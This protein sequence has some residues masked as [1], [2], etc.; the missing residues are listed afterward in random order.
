MPSPI[1]S[2][3]PTSARSVSTSYSSMRCLRIEVISSGR[4]FKSFSSRGGGQFFAE[5]FEA[6]PHARVEAQRA[7][8]DDEAT[9]QARIDGARGDDAA[10]GCLLDL[11]DHA[12]RLLLGELDGG[13]QLELEHALA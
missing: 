3:V 5:L 13:R 6:A 4:S 1:S 7:C 2:T 9:D 12:A 11:L 10:A 8:L